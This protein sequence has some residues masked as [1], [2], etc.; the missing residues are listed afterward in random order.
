MDTIEVYK[1]KRGETRWRRRALNGNILLD[2]GES[3]KRRIDAMKIISRTQ[4]PPY[5]LS[6]LGGSAPKVTIVG[7]FELD[8]NAEQDVPDPELAVPPVSLY[9]AAVE[10]AG[11]VPEMPTPK[12]VEPC[13]AFDWSGQ[14]LQWCS[15]CNW[16]YWEHAYAARSHGVEPI[17][18]E[19]KATV[20]AL[21]RKSVEDQ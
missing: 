21:W 19:S 2:S 8:E 18:E 14:N 11:P 10:A 17:S 6:I 16:P 7:D 3:Y 20:K 9:A 13:G 4:A 12:T 15:Q 5:R 1:D